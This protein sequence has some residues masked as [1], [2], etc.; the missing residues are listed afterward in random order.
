MV[1]ACFKDKT[2]AYRKR[3]S[4]GLCD[5]KTE[6]CDV[7]SHVGNFDLINDLLFISYLFSLRTPFQ[8]EAASGPRRPQ[9]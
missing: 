7:P 5:P 3:C 1:V 2:G 8:N 9:S 4:A 6:P